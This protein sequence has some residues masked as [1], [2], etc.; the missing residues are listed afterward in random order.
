MNRMKETSHRGTGATMQGAIDD[1]YL[2]VDPEEYE[3]YG[4]EGDDD[5]EDYDE[6]GDEEE[7]ED[8]GD[9]GD[10]GEEEEDPFDAQ[11]E[12]R[13]KM[14]KQPAKDQRF[15]RVN[16]NLRNKYSD[17]ELDQFMRILNIRPKTGWEDNTSH[18]Y[19]LGTH[20][21][22]DE[23]QEMDIDFHLLSESERKEADKIATKEWRSGAEV[24]FV[25]DGRV[26]IRPNYRF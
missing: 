2:E 21:Y 11:D 5:D 23:N 10:Y 1:K 19:K 4:A 6:E 9:Y 24:N 25:L 14:R 20:A 12:L 16:D 18:H 7:E 15:F 17:S 3:V 26:P 8:Y 22:E 13:E